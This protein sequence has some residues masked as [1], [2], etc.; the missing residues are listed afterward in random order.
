MTS[1]LELVED[2]EVVV[3]HVEIP[4]KVMGSGLAI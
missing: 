2:T 1:Q 4:K 3:S